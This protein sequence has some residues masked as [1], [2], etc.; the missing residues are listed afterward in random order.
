MTLTFLHQARLK[1]YLQYEPVHDKTNKMTCA[2]TEDSDQPRHLPSLIGV[3]VWS[4]SSLYALI[5]V[6]K[7]Q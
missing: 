7:D 2:P 4:E 3:P 6:A 5:M 1:A